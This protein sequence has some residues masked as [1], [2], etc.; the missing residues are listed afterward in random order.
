[1]REGVLLRE[2][3]R[4]PAEGFVPF[5]LVSSVGG[6][7]STRAMEK[8]SFFRGQKWWWWSGRSLGRRWEGNEQ[9]EIHPGFAGFVLE[10][11]SSRF[12]PTANTTFQL[13][14]CCEAFVG[15]VGTNVAILELAAAPK[16]A[17]LKPRWR[18]YR[19][20]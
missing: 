15:S 8:P 5:G 14:R 6:P 11:S 13:E 12:P 4:P 1:M 9:P 18:S 20:S 17:A 16:G 2:G 10:G 19:P 7:R 3:R